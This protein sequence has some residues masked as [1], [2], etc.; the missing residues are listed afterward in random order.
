[1]VPPAASQHLHCKGQ[2]RPFSVPGM[3][4]LP[5]SGEWDVSSLEA[6]GKVL[7]LSHDRMKVLPSPGG[8]MA[9][10]LE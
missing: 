3:V 2:L 4:S 5:R 6:Y 10:G 9:M 7:A 1:M 8:Y